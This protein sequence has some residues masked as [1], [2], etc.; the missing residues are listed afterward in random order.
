M[1]SAWKERIYR[2]LPDAV[3]SGRLVLHYQPIVDLA[4]PS[5]V[6][7]EA[8]V[9]WPHPE[10]GVLVAGAFVPSAADLG[11]LPYL[12]RWTLRQACAD[13]ARWQAQGKAGPELALSVNVAPE[14][15]ER[16]NFVEETLEIVS[17]TGFHSG[18]LVLEVSEAAK[19]NSPDV[20]SANLAELRDRGVRIAI[21]DFGCKQ[22]LA[23]YH[24]LPADQ[25]K[26]DGMLVRGLSRDEGF[27][28]VVEAVAAMASAESV[29]LVAEG[30]ES[31]LDLDGVRKIGCTLVQGYHI[32]RPMPEP[33]LLEFLDRVRSM[34]VGRE[35]RRRRSRFH[36]ASRYGKGPRAPM[37]SLRPYSEPGG[38]SAF[39]WPPA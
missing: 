4:Y 17:D 18:R 13:V 3:E 28:T 30:V 21:D 12:D 5:V 8:L 6:Q 23:H 19:L 25:L 20:A 22:S 36:T 1:E 2:D 14:E 10:L 26:L 32:A 33:Q 39:E 31:P 34:A 16:T 24:R 37:A 38:S 29:C 35:R 9:R 15:I 11:M 7:V 27:R